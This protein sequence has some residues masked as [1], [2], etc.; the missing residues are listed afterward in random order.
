MVNAQG[1]VTFIATPKPGAPQ[2]TTSKGKR[3]VGLLIPDLAQS[4][5]FSSILESEKSS[6]RPA[7][8]HLKAIW[9]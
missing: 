8:S 6:P 3:L 1:K 5:F 4:P 7:L 9:T 2:T